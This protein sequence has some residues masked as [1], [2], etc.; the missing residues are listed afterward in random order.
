VEEVP[1]VH[2]GDHVRSAPG[3][4]AVARRADCDTGGETD[5]AEDDVRVVRN[6]VRAEGHGWVSGRGKLLEHALTARLG[7]QP[8]KLNV[9]PGR[10][11][12]ERVVSPPGSVVERSEV[13][14]DTVVVRSR[15]EIAR[16][17]RVDRDRGLVLRR[18]AAEV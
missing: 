15:D 14:A 2:E 17:R 11:T 16:V 10:A 4:A 1:R 18:L 8:G 12:V 5:P 7:G 13:A 3:P 6:P 9:P